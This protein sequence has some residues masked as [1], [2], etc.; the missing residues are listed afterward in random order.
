MSQTK[1]TKL[2]RRIF[3]P[4]RL[5]ILL[6]ILMV[7][8]MGVW[9]GLRTAIV[10]GITIGI[11]NMEA[12]GY[13]I[14]HGGLN[15]S[16]FPLS[17]NAASSDISV[18]A[19]AG[20]ADDLSKNWSVKLSDF[21]FG[22][23]T[24]TPLSW[25]FRHRGDMRVDM[26]GAGGER[27]MFDITPAKV[28]A[29]GAI[30]LKGNLKS[31]QID[32]G[33]TTLSPVVGTP[34]IVLGAKDAH[35][36]VKINGANARLNINVHDIILSD[37]GMDQIEHVLGQMFSEFSLTMTVNNWADLETNGP[38]TW[39]KNEGK[40]SS[41]SWALHW[42]KVDLTGDFDIHFENGLPNGLLNIRIK[43]LPQLIDAIDQMG[44][45]DEESIRYA[46]TF[47]KGY[48][49]EEDGRIALP[50]PIRDGWITFLSQPV[51]QL[52]GF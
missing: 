24:I 36:D 46:R 21:N 31:A 39:M 34:P 5:F 47:A 11:R 6:L 16:G 8:I 2:K 35:M 1:K 17:V 10:K 48:K 25:Q 45:V 50:L 28:D 4:I 40:L 44:M 42:G 26:R 18:Q 14:A 20:A 12:E 27:Y 7:L 15:V 51:Y 38:E 43:D 29:R 52:P 19:P 9:L 23:A 33:K 49:P 13:Q 37:L 22:T 32:I 3:T 41:D 30:N